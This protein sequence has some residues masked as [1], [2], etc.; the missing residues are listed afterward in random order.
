M[1]TETLL[2]SACAQFPD[3]DDP[4]LLLVDYLLEKGQVERAEFVKLLLVCSWSGPVYSRI[5]PSDGGWRLRDPN[6]HDP[7]SGRYGSWM[8][9]V[10]RY[11]GG[12][13]RDLE[14]KLL[15]REMRINQ[16]QW[17]TDSGAGGYEPSKKHAIRSGLIYL[18]THGGTE[19]EP[20]ENFL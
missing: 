12:N 7:E 15:C 6:K 19:R 14:S 18:L 16:W 4:K 10:R 3:A 2:I 11:S 1:N 8:M 9:I 17:F 5:K 13:S 20:L